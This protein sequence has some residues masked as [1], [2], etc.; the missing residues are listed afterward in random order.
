[1]LQV[2]GLISHVGVYLF[3][4]N[5]GICVGIYIGQKRTVRFYKPEIVKLMNSNKKYNK[6]IIKKNLLEDWN[7]F[8]K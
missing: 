6:Y 8:D 3:G 1:M 2:G 7:N 4:I 5:V